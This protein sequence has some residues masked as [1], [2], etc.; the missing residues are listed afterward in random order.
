MRNIFLIADYYVIF[1]WNLPL[2]SVSGSFTAA[3]IWM[4]WR[5]FQHT[6]TSEKI[7][8]NEMHSSFVLEFSFNGLCIIVAAV[9]WQIAMTVQSSYWCFYTCVIATSSEWHAIH[10]H[11]YVTYAKERASVST[12]PTSSFIGWLMDGATIHSYLNKLISFFFASFA[13]QYI[14]IGFI[15]GISLVK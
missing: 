9:V 14:F 3:I 8:M 5:K 13:I 6:F 15:I 11:A 7:I 12:L 1:R 2:A 10:T 4:K